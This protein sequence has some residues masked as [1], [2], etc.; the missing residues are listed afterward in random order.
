MAFEL[1]VLD[2]DSSIWKIIDIFM[3]FDLLLKDIFIP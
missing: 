1:P 3:K 2:D